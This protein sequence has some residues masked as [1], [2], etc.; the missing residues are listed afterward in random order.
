[1]IPVASPVDPCSPIALAMRPNTTMME[2]KVTTPAKIDP[3]EMFPWETSVLSV[4]IHASCPV[5]WL[6]AGCVST[7]YAVLVASGAVCTVRVVYCV[8]VGLTCTCG[9]SV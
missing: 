7:V 4:P 5:C 3:Q 6:S 8:S 2:M 1:M 9:C